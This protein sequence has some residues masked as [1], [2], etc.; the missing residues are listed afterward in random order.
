MGKKNFIELLTLAAQPLPKGAGKS[1]P[2]YDYS[3]K[4]ILQRTNRDSVAKLNGK[5]RPKSGG[6]VRKSPPRG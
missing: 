3:D 6:T 4:Q 2:A 1:T 5:S